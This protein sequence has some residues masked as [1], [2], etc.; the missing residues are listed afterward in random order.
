LIR[1][2]VEDGGPGLTEAE[3]EK[4]FRSLDQGGRRTGGAGLGLYSLSKRLDALGGSYGV[5][6]RADG[7]SGCAFWFAFPYEAA[8]TDLVVHK[9]VGLRTTLPS[10]DEERVLHMS[11]AALHLANVGSKL[12]VLVVDDAMSILKVTKMTLQK[13]GYNV[14]TANNGAIGLEKMMKSCDAWLKRDVGQIG[15]QKTADKDAGQKTAAD[16]APLAE[17]F[18]EEV[19]IVLMDLQMPVMGEYA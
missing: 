4:L 1:I 18:V 7:K 13:K 8:P 2:I 9:S 12:R 19:D 5:T 15:Q 16:G 11:P 6:S 17:E 14:D 10:L 3:Q